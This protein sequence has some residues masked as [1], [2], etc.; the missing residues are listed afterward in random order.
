MLEL[1]FHIY[2]SYILSTFSYT[3]LGLLFSQSQEGVTPMN[4]HHLTIHETGKQLST[5]I[6]T[7][8]SQ[9]EVEKRQ[10]KYGKNILANH[11]RISPIIMFI[12]QFQDFMIITL[13]VAAFISFLI[14]LLKGEIDYVDPIIILFIII[15]NALLGTIQ[16]NK[17]EKSLEALKKMSAPTAKVLRNN[18]VSIID[19]KELVPGDLILLEA[20][21]YVPADAR[22]IQSVNL[23]VEESA[24]TGES[25]P[26]DKDAT[27]I[28]KESTPL[29]ERNNLVMATTIVTY[30]RGI[31][32]VTNIG[33]DT[34][35]GHIAKLIMSD[36]AP[37]TPLQKKLGTTSKYLGIS[38]L[39]ICIVIFIIG[40][41]NQMP[42]LDMFMTSVSLAVAAIPEGL[43]AIVTIMLSLGVQRMAKKN[44][45]IRK[46][47]AVETLGS[48]TIICSDKTGTL[49]QNKM[50]VTELNSIYGLES[51]D[52][53][54]GKLLLSL[55]TL[56]NDSTLHIH[57]KEL[58]TS[59]EPT[60]V[61]LAS[62][63]Y[64]SSLYKP[65][66]ELTYPRIFEIPFDS[67]RK[68][69]T[70]IHNQTDSI[71]Q[72]RG[73]FPAKQYLVITKGA[74]DV[75]ILRC[76]QVFENNK[77]S[78][79]TKTKKDTILKLNQAM[80][81]KA[82]RVIAIAY[83][84]IDTLPKDT[85]AVQSTFEEKLIFMGLIGMIDPPRPEVKD[86]VLT[87]KMAGIR[88]IMITGDHI[89]TACAIAR[90]LG[91][92]SPRE[93]AI[94]GIELSHMG[95]RELLETISTCTVFARVSPEHK[96]RIVKAF[97]SQ[98]E[99]VAMTGDGVN[100]APAL[101]A[102]DIG[103]A[104][105]MSGTDVAKNASDMILTD[106]NFATI[107]S[108]IKEGRGIYDN[109]KKSIHFLLSSNIGEIITILIA[110]LF[111]LPSPLLPVQLLWV[112]L[113]TDSLPAISLGMEP[114]EADIMKRKPISSKKGLF[115]DGLV[116]KII[117]EGIMVG[118]LSLCAFV[119]GFR[120]FDHADF[121]LTQ[122]PLIGRTMAF[123]V[124]SLSQLFHSFNMRSSK[125]LSRIGLFSN[126]PLLYSF[127]ICAFLQIAVVMFP[128]LSLIFKVTPLNGLQWGIVAF[129]SFLPIVLVELQKNINHNTH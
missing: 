69:M 84:E 65:K 96:V 44:A 129:L 103:C 81:H 59:G 25:I 34:Q 32:I 91:I 62:A 128:P 110:I 97:Q 82:L 95:D 75:L 71:F 1:S 72:K 112:N 123:T 10:R 63:A 18:I 77:L 19:S 20:G 87:C 107:V 45:V 86:A 4:W 31:G 117:L 23:K 13:I 115:A 114:P 61:A 6:E 99:V 16:E 28:L 85:S 36:T 11:K 68:L 38:A 94:T 12:Q 101:K 24:L 113:V 14:S 108:A 35:V 57:K 124:L 78:P 67:K 93:L 88:P 3:Y 64:R 17:A 55:S 47:P 27:S 58:I 116:F 29:S 118:S 100:D 7:G 46:L 105:G 127:G 80:A 56:C 37:E 53:Y 30:G 5:T 9:G 119:I 104:M 41:M 48:A 83:K 74:P 8:L 106:D 125:S 50:T 26:V 89:T 51:P 92:W 79:M 70:T 54:F 33:M 121:S 111:G 120:F 43:P 40:L 102:A 126:P 122:D 66:L 109:I 98:G 42:I 73:H 90:E 2:P 39:L 15:L 21:H 76:N 49:T 22:L 60:E 52:S